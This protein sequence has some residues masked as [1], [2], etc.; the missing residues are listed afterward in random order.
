[1]AVQLLVTLG[2]SPQA[3]DVARPRAATLSGGTEGTHQPGE[4]G[5]GGRGSGV[6]SKMGI[7]TRERRRCMAE[8]ARVRRGGKAVEQC[9]RAYDEAVM[10]RA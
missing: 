8:R 3:G 9:V 5:G 7:Q 1:M 2:L 6:R 10:V 4:R